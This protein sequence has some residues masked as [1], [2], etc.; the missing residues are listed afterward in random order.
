MRLRAEV[1][2]AKAEVPV[3]KAD[4]FEAPTQSLW[5]NLW[6]TS[7]AKAMFPFIALP[8]HSFIRKYKMR[9]SAHVYK[10]MFACLRSLN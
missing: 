8:S 2:M 4:L 6:Q 5:H 10:I 1:P 3:T 7:R 9:L